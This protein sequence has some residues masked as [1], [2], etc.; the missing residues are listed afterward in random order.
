MLFIS[1]DMEVVRH[2]S[3]RIAVM[4]E[5]RITD[6]VEQTRYSRASDATGERISDRLKGIDPEPL[7]AIV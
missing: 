5:G 3:D 6:T 7:K 4:N 2:M 1:H